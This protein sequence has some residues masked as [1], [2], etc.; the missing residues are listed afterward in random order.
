MRF[1][2]ASVFLALVILPLFAGCT[3]STPNYKFK[4]EKNISHVYIN[5]D[6]SIDIE[7]HITFENLG[8]P[9]DVVDIGLPHDGYRLDTARADVNSFPLNDIDHS[10]YIA[11]G[12]EVQ[13]GEHAIPRSHSGTLNFRIN[14]PKMV[15]PDTEDS[16]Y[17]SMQFSPTWFYPPFVAG[18]T[19]VEVHVHFPAGVSGNE[20][21]YHAV[22]PTFD[23]YAGDRLI[24]TWVKEAARQEKMMVGVSFPK[25]YVDKVCDP[26]E[27][28]FVE[29]ME[30][31]EPF[32]WGA[33]AAWLPYIIIITI[34]V[35]GSLGGAIAKRTKR[36]HYLPPETRIEGLGPC[37]SLDPIE[38]AIVLELPLSRI[39]ALAMMQLIQK[40]C[41]EVKQVHPLR[42]HILDKDKPGL[43]AY[44]E[45]ILKALD[46]AKYD[47]EK[48]RERRLHNAVTKLIEG[49]RDKLKKGFSRKATAD[50]YRGKIEHMW[51]R[52]ERDPQFEHLAWIALNDDYVKEI[53]ESPAK[54]EKLEPFWR[55]G[56]YDYFPSQYRRRSMYYIFDD[57]EEEIVP[58]NTGFTHVVSKVTNPTAWIQS[59]GWSS[60]GGGGGSCACA[61]AGCACA[62][63][64]G[65]R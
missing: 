52:I 59:S 4:V 51:G 62:C 16:K 32:N 9:I 21:K 6:G 12:V 23:T 30:P 5:D 53:E 25:K 49:V 29:S 41:I 48:A 60:G 38:A 14:N 45:S 56:Y 50:F 55:D 28:T 64:G 39:V 3:G 35:L 10:S 31:T 36:M 58:D 17:A 61:C 20:T 34:A 19:R 47:D 7:Y 40:K 11:V 37:R 43:K 2:K 46:P 33:L 22:P 15:F 65:G 42:V 1:L 18:T 13:L 57:F 24:F 8:D 26:S 27:V 44:E 54:Q 63:A